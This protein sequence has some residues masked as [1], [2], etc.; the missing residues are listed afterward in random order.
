MQAD[1]DLES[2]DDDA[3]SRSQEQRPRWPSGRR[4]SSILPLLNS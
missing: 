1:W 4:G 3:N 2:S